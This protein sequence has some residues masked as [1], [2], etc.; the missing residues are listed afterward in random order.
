MNP[1][2]AAFVVPRE[3]DLGD[4]F[5][6]RRVLPSAAWRSV[7]PFVRSAVDIRA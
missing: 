1:D 5:I 7:G 6:V 3:A 2:I 4:G